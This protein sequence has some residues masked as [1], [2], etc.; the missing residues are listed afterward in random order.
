MFI[1]WNHI[2]SFY[3]ISNIHFYLKI[4][5]SFDYLTQ[6]VYLFDIYYLFYYDIS[7]SD[8][9]EKYRLLR[10][11]CA[12]TPSNSECLNLKQIFLI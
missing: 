12:R 2:S 8:D 10:E 6:C 5:K 7:Y 9:L 4:T 11:Q 1:I 3:F